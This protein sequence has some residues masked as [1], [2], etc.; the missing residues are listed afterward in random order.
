[1]Q[2]TRGSFLFLAFLLVLISVCNADENCRRSE[3]ARIGDVPI[4]SLGGSESPLLFISGLLI[5]AD[6]SPFAYNP[7]D[8]GLDALHNAGYPGHWW[9]IATNRDGD[10]MVQGHYDPAPGYFVSTTALED[11]S[12]E[13]SDPDRYVDSST[14]SYISVPPQFL[15]LARLGDLA[16]VINLR[17]GKSA[18]AIIAD[19]GPP[20]RIGEGSI[21]L[22][23]QLDLN[24][25]ARDGGTD[26][27]IMYIVFPNSGDGTPQSNENIQ[28][29]AREAFASWAPRFTC[30][31][32][33]ND[34]D[35]GL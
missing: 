8:T 22:A 15:K 17:N 24:P 27:E 28:S 6:G 26:A 1:M 21:A 23:R 12:V 14:I 19:I 25:D 33:E 9:G 35:V 2:R 20:D 3:V 10:P 7:Q 32:Q 16:M 30:T 31:E 11:R 13:A 18:G 5:D 4:L 34:D 29:D